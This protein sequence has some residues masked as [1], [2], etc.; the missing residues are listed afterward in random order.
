MAWNRA[1]RVLLRCGRAA[2][3]SLGIRDLWQHIEII[4]GKAGPGER[5]QPAVSALHF[6]NVALGLW[7]ECGG[8]SQVWA[9]GL[10]KEGHLFG[11][12]SSKAPILEQDPALMALRAAFS[13]LPCSRLRS[14]PSKG[15]ACKVSLSICLSVQHG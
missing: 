15:I 10:N 7:T 11:W 5:Q 4:L 6:G 1:E 14:G 13:A 2:G 3:G 9:V 12:K 8:C